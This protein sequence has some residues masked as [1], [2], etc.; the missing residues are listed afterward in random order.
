MKELKEGHGLGGFGWREMPER[1]ELKLY[2]EK[3]VFR[4]VFL[5][6]AARME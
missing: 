6:R 5:A 1:V 4:K 3:P 2:E